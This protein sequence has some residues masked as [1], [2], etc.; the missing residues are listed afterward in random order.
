MG[1]DQ[2]FIEIFRGPSLSRDKL[3]SSEIDWVPQ[4]EVYLCADPEMPK[5]TFFAARRESDR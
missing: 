3:Q 4:L 5:S 2:T 1:W